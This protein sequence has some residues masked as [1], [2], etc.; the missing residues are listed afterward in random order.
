MPNH[1]ELPEKGI[2]HIARGL[3]ISQ[4]IG[5]ARV[6]LCQHAKKL[7]YYLPGGHIE[8]GETAA[9]ALAREMM[10]EAGEGVCVHE[11]VHVHEHAFVQKDKVRQEINLTHRASLAAEGATLRT[12]QSKEDGIAFAWLTIEELLR[13][14]LRPAALRPWICEQMALQT[15]SQMHLTLAVTH[16]SHNTLRTRP[17]VFLDR[18]GTI[19]REVHYIAH[20]Q[21]VELLPGAASAIASLRDAGFACIMVSNQSGVGR[22]MVSQTAMWQVQAEVSR[23]LQASGTQLDGVDFCPIA[24]A[25]ETDSA[26]DRRSRIDHP[27]RKP[28]P[29]M[30]LRAAKEHNLDLSR[31][32]MIGD[33]LS[34]VLA[35]KN[36][37]CRGT[38]HVQTGHGSK[39]LQASKEATYAARDLAE[40]AR[41]VL[42]Q[43]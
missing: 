34:D 2:E 40:A 9:I 17:A 32:W 30:L 21:Q 24:P 22:G 3:I 29:G 26:A 7:Y 20:P 11:L 23:Q 39:E 13:A 14:D 1:P 36:A 28:A 15:A 8:P 33:M 12:V 35:G 43:A 18:D 42:S 16:H 25:A 38:I 31:S 37:G 6:L 5:T 27:D 10:E 4:A 41:W 19:I